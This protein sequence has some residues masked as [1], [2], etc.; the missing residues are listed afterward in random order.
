MKST[1][2]P[3]PSG[4]TLSY[5]HVDPHF[6][7]DRDVRRPANL[8]FTEVDYAC[9][10]GIAWVA[11]MTVSDAVRIAIDEYVARRAA[12]PEI[13][14]EI[15][16]ANRR[17]AERRDALLDAIRMP[18]AS[19]LAMPPIRKTIR[20]AIDVR[21]ITIRLTPHHVNKLTAFALIDDN[22][23]ARQIR[24]SV[25]EHLDRLLTVSRAEF[26]AVIAHP[27]TMAD[28]TSYLR[29]WPSAR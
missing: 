20:K 24:R 3:S 29:A 9:L 1:N 13:E 21:P 8:K 10:Q 25:D 16:A 23:V 14:R 7:G 22:T 2:R 26:A 17:D 4:T 19:D 27:E 6:D 5:P 28:V 18:D 11:R 15:D 12:S